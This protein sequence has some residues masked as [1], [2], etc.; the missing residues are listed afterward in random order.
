MFL[1]NDRALPVEGISNIRL[2]MFNGIVRT[3]K[4]WHVLGLKRNLI[5]LGTLDSHGSNTMQRIEFSKCERT[6]WYS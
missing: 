2:R 5:S 1:G 4:C 6:L 3:I